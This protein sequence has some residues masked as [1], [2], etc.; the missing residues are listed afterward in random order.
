MNANNIREA[1]REF[2][3]KTPLTIAEL[4]AFPLFLRIALVEA[5]TRI[6]THVSNAQQLREAAYLWANRL[7]NAARLGSQVFQKTLQSLEP[8][9]VAR[10]PYF[11]TALAEQLQ[12]EESALGP[13]QHWIEE[14]F[15]VSLIELVRRQHTGEAAEVISTANAFGSLRALSQI[16][17]TKIFEEVSLVEAELRRDPSGVYLQSDF[18]TRDRCRRIVERTARYSGVPEPAVAARAVELAS[19]GSSERTRYVAYYLLS[20]GLFE[21][22][23]STKARIPARVAM[24]RATQAQAAPVY[25][26]AIALLTAGFTALA[27]LLARDAGFARSPPSDSCSTGGVSAERTRPPDCERTGHFTAAAGS[28]SE[29]GF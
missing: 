10:D 25:I 15:G 19:Q 9:P 3:V 26:G 27:C 8:E 13:V 21:L 22:E 4:W 5:L 17:F 20:D 7:A 23:R 11:V 12:D 2:Q 28:S 16:D 1:L 14:R 24:R 29:D 18:A 6:A